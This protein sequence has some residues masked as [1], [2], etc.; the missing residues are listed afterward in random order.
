[1]N[2]LRVVRVLH[3]FPSAIVA[4][5]TLVLGLFAERGDAF[6]AP[7]LLAI[8]MLFYQFSIGAAND[9]VDRRD[10]AFAKPWKPIPAG[11]V[12]ASAAIALAVACLAA[13]ALLSVSFGW[14]AWLIGLGGVSLGL[15]YDV[16][17]KRTVLSW[18][19][20]ALAFPTVPLWVYVSFDEWDALLL[21]VLPLG[22]VLGIAIHLANQAPDVEAGDDGLPGAFGERNSRLVAVALFASTGL[23]T[24]GLIASRS[25]AFALLAAALAVVV[26]AVGMRAHCWFG[27]DGLFRLL[28]FAAVGLTVCFFG[29]AG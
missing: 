27:V 25:L 2:A 10:D 19:P 3:P 29:A 12:P 14:V 16:W 6:A 21:T 13:G 20:F 23:A 1:M 24:A 8:A 15:L 11:R 9:V 7:L 17:L 26:A 22:F 18:L 4:V 28:A 5:T